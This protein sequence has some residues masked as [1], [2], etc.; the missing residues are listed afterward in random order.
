MFQLVFMLLFAL[1]WRRKPRCASRSAQCERFDQNKLDAPPVT[2]K[3]EDAMPPP[4]LYPSEPV[5]LQTFTRFGQIEA[6][7]KE[8]LEKVGLD[9]SR[10]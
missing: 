7:G 4:P 5:A 9:F 2:Q 10:R 1:H 3:R 6:H 8:K